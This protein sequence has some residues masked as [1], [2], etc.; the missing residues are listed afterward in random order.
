MA[1]HYK[2]VVLRRTVLL[3][4]T[5][6]AVTAMSRSAP[7]VASPGQEH[8]LTVRADSTALISG[9]RPRTSVWTYDGRVPGPVLRRRQGEPMRIVVHN[10]LEQD[11]TVHWHGIRLPIAMDGVQGISQ[12]PIRP[13][14]SFT[15]AFTPPDAFPA[16]DAS[17]GRGRGRQSSSRPDRGTARRCRLLDADDIAAGIAGDRTI[18]VTQQLA[19][20]RPE[21]FLAMV[22]RWLSCFFSSSCMASTSTSELARM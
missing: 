16:G 4:A 9:G 21:R 20:V 1:I 12:P 8:E 6:L 7:A 2:P 13:N 18:G 11:T 14:D 15:Y 3:T 17:D 5:G 22:S 10:K 19:F